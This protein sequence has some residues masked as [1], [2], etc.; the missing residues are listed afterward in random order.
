MTSIAKRSEG[1]SESSDR[2]R[3]LW[4]IAGLIGAGVL[5]LIIALTLM[6]CS[7]KKP[8]A[9]TWESTV[10]VPLASDHFT[11]ANLLLRLDNGSQFVDE[12]GNIGLNLVDTLAPVSLGTDFTIPTQSAQLPQAVGEFNVAGPAPEA[13]RLNLADYYSGSPGSVPPFAVSDTDTIGPIPEYTWMAPAYGDAYLRIENQFGL[14][15]DSVFVTLDDIA[16]GPLGTFSFSNGIPAGTADSQSIGIAGRMLYNQFQYTLSAY[17]SGGTL[18]SLSNRYLDVAVA[19]S[20]SV[21]IDSALMEIPAVTR[22]RSENVSFTGNADLLS[23]TQADLAA[24]MLTFAADNRTGLT[25]DVSV[26]VPSLTL[27]GVPLSRNLT[28]PPNDTTSLSV[29]LTNYTW[30]PEQSAA[31]QYFVVNAVASTIPSAPAHVLVRMDDSIFVTAQL[32]GAQALSVTGVVAPQLVSLP[33]YSEALAIPPEFSSFHLAQALLTIE[34]ENGSGAAADLNFDITGDNGN[35]LSVSGP[36]AAGSPTTPAFTTYTEPNLASF[37]DPFPTQVDIV[38]SAAFGDSVTEYTVSTN[39]YAAAIVSIT[40]PLA[41]RVDSVTVQS[42]VSSQAI[43]GTDIAEFTDNL[44]GGSLH[45]H[46]TNHLPLGAAVTLFV[47]TDSLNVYS[48]PDLVLGP[49]AVSP[50]T[51]DSFGLVSEAVE[52]FDEVSLTQTDLQLFDS[53]QLYIGQYIH[54]DGT[55]G[56]TVQFVSAD[57]LDLV[58]YFTATMRNGGE[59]W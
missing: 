14:D 49:V 44:L 27:G 19:F 23:V 7:L 17:T 21:V 50:G 8:E 29:D 28:L 46:A 47:A 51:T 35:S 22:T 32:Q 15:F 36:A 24:G 57:Y 3:R 12:N 33:A 6:Q 39:D 13:V 5:A 55:A 48:A 1:L 54:F 56:D 43:S 10:T 37:L 2:S 9:P 38:T 4:R 52:T 34:L 18:L 42:E 41:V 26:T 45:L 11:I 31:P 20:D 30:V 25:A 58:A 53:T 59:V 16:V 40:A